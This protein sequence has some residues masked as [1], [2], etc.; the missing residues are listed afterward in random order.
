[1]RSDEHD[2]TSEGED[3][4]VI[5]SDLPELALGVSEGR[6]R[7]VVLAHLERC[8]TCSAELAGYAAAVDGL[9]Q[10]APPVEPPAG[11]EA[12][13]LERARLECPRTNRR[14]TRRRLALAVAAFVL[15]GGGLAA[16]LV[17]AGPTPIGETHPLVATLTGKGIWRGD[18]LVSP[19]TPAWLLVVIDDGSY[20][21]W[22]TC[23]VETTTGSVLTVGRYDLSAGYGAW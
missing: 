13:V 2:G 1:M 12:R 9:A 18:V 15:L 10:L 17:A 11:F 14:R 7:S 20:S 6:R 23:Q 22:I 3:C 16:G 4:S 19:G 5:L 8:A 21:G